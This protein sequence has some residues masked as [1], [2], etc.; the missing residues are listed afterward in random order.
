MQGI[1]FEV[2]EESRKSKDANRKPPAIKKT[3]PLVRMIMRS[4]V[5]NPLIADLILLGVSAAFFGATI[6]LYSNL[7]GKPKKYTPTMQEIMLMDALGTSP[8]Q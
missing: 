5:E 8:T 7:L 6:Y 4:G 2:D 1:E 3:G